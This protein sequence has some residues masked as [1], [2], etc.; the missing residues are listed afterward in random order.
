MKKLTKET[1]IVHGIHT[2]HSTSRDLVPPIHMTSTFK[3]KDSDHGAEI[4]QGTSQGYVYTRIS[5]P[6]VDLL[7]EKMAVLEE[8][9]SAIATSSGMSAIA[10]VSMALAKPGH[11]FVA[12]STVY[13]GTFAFFNKHLRDLNIEPRFIHPSSHGSKAQVERLVD[14]Q[15][16]FLYMETPANP[17]LD[18][19][20]IEMWASVAKTHGVPLIVDNT[21][22]SSYLQRPLKLGAEIVVHSATK[23]LSGHGDIV[24]GII[25]GTEKMTDYIKEEYIMHYGPAIS[26]FN[27]WLILRGIKTLAL[28]MEKHSDNALK[29]AQWLE[30]HPKV[31]EVH[32]PGLNTHP[33]HHIAKKQMKKFGGMV[34]FEVKGG[35]EAGKKVMDNVELCILAVSLGDCETLIQ[36]PASMTHSTYTKEERA[37]AGIT[38]GLIR[39][40]LG[41]ED[42]DDIIRDLENALSL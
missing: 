35:L 11:N 18:V 29:V 16:K 13:G 22:A 34:A 12:C 33:D 8:G 19:I 23:Y 31:T 5:N 1:E 17:T 37:K 2:T 42:A 10:S 32:Y 39:L 40:S 36:H 24:G 30:A 14:N 3:F 20:D 7:Q 6:T 9:E 4:F 38:D 25:V 41:I 28:R 26:P 27:A 15:T 21:F